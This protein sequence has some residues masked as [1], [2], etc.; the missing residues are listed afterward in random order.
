MLSFWLYCTSNRPD[1]FISAL[2]DTVNNGYEGNK[3]CQVE[4]RV[5]YH[6]LLC[7][8]LRD[9]RTISKRFPKGVTLITDDD[10]FKMTD[11]MLD[12]FE[13]HVGKN[14]L[15]SSQDFLS[16]SSSPLQHKA[17]KLYDVRFQWISYVVCT[18]Y[19]IRLT[20]T[21]LWVLLYIFCCFTFFILSSYNYLVQV[22]YFI[23]ILS[24][25]WSWIVV[26]R[27]IFRVSLKLLFK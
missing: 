11:K 22:D 16:F 19:I 13:Y 1:A 4:V 6:G 26:G 23:F 18:F 8:D 3:S 10:C 21:K 27:L 20:R 24:L 17:G 25:L 12:G 15:S 2:N 14:Y 7:S 5:T 9:I